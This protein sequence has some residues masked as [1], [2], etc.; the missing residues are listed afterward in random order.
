M[1]VRKETTHKLSCERR[2]CSLSD[3]DI[4]E[5]PG[6]GCEGEENKEKIEYSSPAQYLI[7]RVLE[8][9]GRVTQYLVPREVLHSAAPQP[10]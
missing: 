2:Y 4:N 3:N 7:G 9:R 8:G 5:Y 1:F 10:S 6:E